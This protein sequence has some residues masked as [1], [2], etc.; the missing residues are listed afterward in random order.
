MEE[1]SGR[2]SHGQTPQGMIGTW[3]QAKGV[4]GGS[5][6]SRETVAD[7]GTRNGVQ[8]QVVEA[9]GWQV[10]GGGV[11]QRPGNFQ[12]DGALHWERGWGAGEK[13]E[14]FDE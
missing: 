8:V 1:T 10:A 4:K 7:A 12:V 14:V 11:R 6:P 13:L 3:V 9:G 2:E 5:A